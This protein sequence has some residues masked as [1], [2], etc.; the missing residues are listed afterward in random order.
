M[1]PPNPKTQ[2][3]Q[4]A[5]T[6]VEVLIAWHSG[7]PWSSAEQPPEVRECPQRETGSGGWMSGWL[8]GHGECGAAVPN[9]VLGTQYMFNKQS[10]IIITL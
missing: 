3:L 10:Q 2:G 6:C 4:V 1:D 7:L 5:G 9:S 8:H